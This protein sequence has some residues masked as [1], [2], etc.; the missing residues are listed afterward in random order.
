[1]EFVRN[2]SVIAIAILAAST[3]GCATEPRVEPDIARAELVEPWGPD[4]APMAPVRRVLL[5]EVEPKLWMVCRPFFDHESAVTLEPIDGELDED[6]R[7]TEPPSTWRLTVTSSWIG[8]VERGQ[9]RWNFDWAHADRDDFTV[10][11]ATVGIDAVIAK[12]IYEAW[13][14]ITRRAR[15]PEPQYMF[16]SDGGRS[17]LTWIKSDGV[18]YEFGCAGFYGETHSPDSA[19]AHDLAALAQHL[20]A[21]PSED[22]AKREA[23]LRACA[24]DARRLRERAEALPW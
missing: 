3:C 7:P 24:E 11:T 16:D 18:R 10:S 19:P 4:L 6:G 12:D 13:K 20:R 8:R 15:Q 1:M 14:L 21:I 17:D 5:P 22:A 2:R 23:A 9:V